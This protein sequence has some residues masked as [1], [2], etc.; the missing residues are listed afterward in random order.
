MKS[1]SLRMSVCRRRLSPGHA[2][3][4]QARSA[5]LPCGTDLVG[6]ERVVIAISSG[7]R[8]PRTG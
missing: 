1:E 4:L 7:T 8:R 6:E 5:Q 2:G 3:L